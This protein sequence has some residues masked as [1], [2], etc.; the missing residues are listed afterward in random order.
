MK[1]EKTLAVATLGCRTNQYDS[2]ALREALEKEGYKIVPF[3]KKADIYLVNSC[4]VTEKAIT[5]SRRKINQAR[6]KNPRAKIILTGCWPQTRKQDLPSVFFISG[7]NQRKKIL[8]ILKKNIKGEK[9]VPFSGKEKFEETGIQRFAGRQRAIVKV[10]E[11]CRQFCSY[12]II[13]YARGHLRSRS[14]KKTV[15]EIKKLIKNGYNDITLTGTHI[16]LYGIDLPRKN[17]INLTFLVEKILKIKELK[18]VRLSSIEPN[19]VT[20]DLIRLMKKNQKFYPG[21]HIPLQSGSDK[22]LKLMNRPY[23]VKKFEQKIGLIRKNIPH[24]K[25]TTDIIVG[26]PGEEEKDFKD[27]Y[28]FCKKLKFAKIHVFSF[29]PRAGTPAAEFLGQVPVKIIKIRS[30]KLRELNKSLK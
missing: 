29:S 30:K 28:N 23:T 15:T 18:Y 19:E 8:N 27:T 4:A 25:I 13:P 6:T 17:K 5:K 22:I 11:G 24:I 12:C 21:F 1:K 16:G 20:P 2:Q 7:T 3:D 9:V 26:F 10:Q 14:W